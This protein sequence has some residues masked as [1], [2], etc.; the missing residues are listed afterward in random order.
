MDCV[1]QRRGVFF[2]WLYRKRRGWEG[3]YE[4]KGRN[5]VSERAKISQAM[6]RYNNVHRVIKRKVKAKIARVTKQRS[7]LSG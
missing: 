7:G 5:S 2:T 4:S 3:G 6:A 1:R